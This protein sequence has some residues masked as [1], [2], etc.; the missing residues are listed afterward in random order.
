MEICK[1][2]STSI[3]EW[4]THLVHYTRDHYKVRKDNRKDDGIIYTH[5]PGRVSSSRQD[6]RDVMSLTSFKSLRLQEPPGV[7]EV[8]RANLAVEFVSGCPREQHNPFFFS[9]SC[10]KVNKGFKAGMSNPSESHW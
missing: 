9:F 1:S 4:I 8:F 3:V 7:S 2:A 5:A 10:E 6:L